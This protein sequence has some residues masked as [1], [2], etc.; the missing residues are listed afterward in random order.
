MMN[1]RETA[2]AIDLAAT[3]WV[4]RLDR[5]GVDASVRA[6]LD[7]WLAVDVRRHGAFFRAQAAWVMLDRASAL[8]GGDRAR[9]TLAA[10]ADAPP[11]VELGSSSSGSGDWAKAVDR[12]EF[13]GRAAFAASMVAGIAGLL[14]WRDR[15]E[16]IETALGEIR[17]V[18]LRD[19]S[20]AAINTAS[21]ISVNLKPEVRKIELAQGEAW[22][23]VAKDR[24]RPF[25]VEAGDVR[26]RA[27]GTAFSVRRYDNGADVRVTEGVVEVWNVADPTQI[28]RVEAGASSF[29]ANDAPPLT[30]IVDGDGNDRALAW[31]S[32]QLVFDGDT[33]E[34]AAK[35]FNRYN[36]VQVVIADPSLAAEKL[37]GRFRT[38]EPDA[39]AR[40]AAGML[41]AKADFSGQEIRL[42]RN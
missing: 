5:E 15:H 27:V 28:R 6:D 25:V 29:V 9:D 36:A 19:G 26:V 35:E 8:R 14:A 2:E 39:F 32:G 17:R 37:V 1:E 24:S 13:L 30:P 10:G 21:R 34:A 38:N 20:L 7:A 18:P 33:L 16:P 4:G 31:R 12:R 3:E 42:R 22:F 41:G 40:A 23:Q 11:P